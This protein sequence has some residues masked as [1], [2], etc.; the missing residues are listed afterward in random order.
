MNDLQQ[1]CEGIAPQKRLAKLYKP[2]EVPGIFGAVSLLAKPRYLSEE[3]FLSTNLR[4]DAWPVRAHALIF[5][6][7][8]QSVGALQTVNVNVR[9]ATTNAYHLTR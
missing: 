4:D 3:K 8:A 7:R 6:S 5:L 2:I 9:D 1:R